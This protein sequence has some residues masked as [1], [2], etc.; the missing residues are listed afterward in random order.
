MAVKP[1]SV[2]IADDHHL[3]VH[4]LK[5]LVEDTLGLRCVAAVH[6]GLSCIDRVSACKPDLIILDLDLP[7]LR[8]DDAIKLLKQASAKSKILV[9]TATTTPRVLRG[10]WA[11]GV[12][13]IV[14]KGAPVNHICKAIS[15]VI[16]GQHYIAPDISAIVSLKSASESKLE[17]LTSREREVFELLVRRFSISSMSDQLSISP[18]TI[19]NHKTHIMAKLDVHS[20]ADLLAFAVG[21]GFEEMILNDSLE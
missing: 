13:G 6:D 21:V 10:V 18:K 16:S 9:I 14:L 11:S 2:L 3:V 5:L 1:Q 8:G 15:T 7:R 19:D 17:S 20:R 4:S 12:H